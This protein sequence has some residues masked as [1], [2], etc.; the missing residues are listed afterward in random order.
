MYAEYNTI[1]IF[2]PT[3]CGEM[4]NLKLYLL[5]GVLHNI[6]QAAVVIYPDPVRPYVLYYKVLHHGLTSTIEG[7]SGYLLYLFVFVLSDVRLFV[8]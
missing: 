4:A 1:S 6:F 3:Q 8:S 2:N 7:D 5:Y